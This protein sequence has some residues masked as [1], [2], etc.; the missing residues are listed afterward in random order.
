M[1][2][3]A[4]VVGLLVWESEEGVLD[5]S[6]LVCTAAGGLLVWE[7]ED[8]GGV[9]AGLIW[10]RSQTQFAYVPV[11]Y[12]RTGFLDVPNG[13]IWFFYVRFSDHHDLKPYY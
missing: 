5:K 1:L 13:G 10:G 9:D 3:C 11:F 7:L 12:R 6:C 4:G 8:S 2:V